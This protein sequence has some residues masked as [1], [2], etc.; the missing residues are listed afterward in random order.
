MYLCIHLGTVLYFEGTKIYAC[1]YGIYGYKYYSFGPTPTLRFFIWIPINDFLENETINVQ[2][3]FWWKKST[4]NCPSFSISDIFFLT[5]YSTSSLFLRMNRVKF[6]FFIILII[7][8]FIKVFFSSFILSSLYAAAYQPVE[9]QYRREHSTSRSVEVPPE[10][11]KG[12]CVLRSWRCLSLDPFT[13]RW[14]ISLGLMAPRFLETTSH[15]ETAW[16]NIRKKKKYQRK[17]DFAGKNTINTFL[18]TSIECATN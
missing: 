16:K 14:Y 11:K 1:M 5:Q 13:I 17:W 15:R 8:F 2:L 6:F 18:I 3:H 10:I 7:F 4:E 9:V 12:R